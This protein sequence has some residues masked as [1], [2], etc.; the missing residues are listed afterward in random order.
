MI[1]KTKKEK[2]KKHITMPLRWEFRL[3][4]L[5]SRQISACFGHFGLFQPFQSPTDMTRYGRYGSILA[6]STRYGANWCESKPSRCKSSQVGSNPRKKK[7]SDA[8]PTRRQQH[9]TLRPASSR[10]GLKCGT[11]PAASMLSSWKVKMM[12]P[13]ELNIQFN[14]LS[15][16]T[17]NVN[18]S[19]NENLS[20]KEYLY[21]FQIIVS[22]YSSI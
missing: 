18:V 6:K 15:L 3:F 20:S 7:S 11:L 21:L 4:W 8:T 17:H 10:I 12:T 13:I 5:N 16:E 2:G 14:S 19:E 1:H 22:I 9:R